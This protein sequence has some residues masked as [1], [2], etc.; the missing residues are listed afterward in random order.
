MARQQE[1]GYALADLVLV[2]A[3]PAREPPLDEV[4][5]HEQPVEVRRHLLVGLEDLRRGGLLGELGEA[6][7]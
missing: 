6:K 5:L 1:V 7:L 3:V 4:R 2:L